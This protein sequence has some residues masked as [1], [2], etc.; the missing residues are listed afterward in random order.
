MS[1]ITLRGLAIAFGAGTLASVASAGMSTVVTFDGGDQ[2]GWT[3]PQ[4]PGGAT[5]IDLAEGN[6][7][8]SL[9]TQ[10]NNFGINFRNNTNPSFVRDLSV[11]EEVTFSVDVLVNDIS[12]TGTPVSRP[13]VLELRDVDN[14]SSAPWDSVFFDFGDISAATEGEWTTFSVTIANPS[15][16]ELPAG[17]RGAGADDPN[18]F[19]P[20]LPAGRNFGDILSTYDEIALTTLEPGFFFGFTDFD[21]LIDNIRIET[22]PAPGAAALFGLGAIGVMRR[23]R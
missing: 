16:T 17:W 20:I 1:A 22:V 21:V 3:G 8:P 10:F 11:Y 19:E 12:F 7:A 2:Q 13:W 18:T 9:R 14:D 5:F 23:R 15:Q 6:G 4:G